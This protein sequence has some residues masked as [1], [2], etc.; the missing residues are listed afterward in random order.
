MTTQSQ[1][2][3]ETKSVNASSSIITEYLHFN[4]SKNVNAWIQSDS[5]DEK[6][7]WKNLTR[8]LVELLRQNYDY[9]KESNV[10]VNIAKHH[11]ILSQM[12]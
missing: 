11:A 8:Q 6:L 7:I 1:E 12:A 5:R 9:S 2:N 10:Y 3:D 4:L